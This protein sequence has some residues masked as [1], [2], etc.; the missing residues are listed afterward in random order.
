M[1]KTTRKGA[2]SAEQTFLQLV[3]N[4]GNKIL[5]VLANSGYNGGR[6]LGV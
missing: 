4:K 3:E 5:A 6:V 2:R 1:Y